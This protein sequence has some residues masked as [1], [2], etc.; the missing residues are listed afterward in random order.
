MENITHTRSDTFIK[1]ISFKDSTWKPID[2]TGSNILFTVKVKIDDV[3]NVLQQAFILT[4]PL[5]WLADVQIDAATMSLDIWNY[6]FDIQWTDSAWIV[7]TV[8]KG[9][10]LITY[11]VTT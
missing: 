11:E 6:I 4:D 2:L 7:K 5:N 1:S 10:F 8:L 9:N 3:W